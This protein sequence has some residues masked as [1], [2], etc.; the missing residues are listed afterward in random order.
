[1][2]YFLMRFPPVKRLRFNEALEG[3]FIE[4]YNKESLVQLR[5]A[6]VVGMVL[7]LVFGLNDLIVHPEYK[8]PLLL[9]RYALVSPFLI[10]V[11]LYL[12]FG[13]SY[14]LRHIF[15]VMGII[16][17]GI[18]ISLSIFITNDPRQFYY[19]G[20]T[21]LTLFAY[22]VSG[23][24]LKFASIASL[25]II[26]IF[27]LLG[28]FFR[29]LPPSAIFNDLFGLFSVNIMGIFACYLMERAKRKEFLYKREIELDKMALEEA[30]AQLRY[31]SYH[32]TLTGIYNRRAFDEHLR[33]E[34]QRAIRFG[35]P[36]SLIMMDIDD[37]K[38]FNDS[39]GHIAGDRILKEIATVIKTMV[40]RPGDIG[41][42]Y[43][44][45][46]F[47]V[48][49]VGTAKEGAVYLAEEILKMIGELSISHP[50]SDR[51]MVTVSVGCTTVIP[52]PEEG[53]E[54][55]IKKAD[56]ALYRAKT[57]GKNRVCY[58]D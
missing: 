54:S 9:I 47:V 35:Y 44:G 34:W 42:R 49:L 20:L 14:L 55:F 19:S 56:E 43:G 8:G 15:F 46:E 18:G 3:Q 22:T 4:F 50:E 58:L 38:K 45:E 26:G 21:L 27:V 5:T 10:S 33:K 36:L 57:E 16:L 28:V 23:L 24:R 39:K 48:L 29:N 52:E 2:L 1:M 6:A 53:V 12:F 51:G 41:A 32:D 37:F 40:N 25:F 7:Y 17:T 13:R 31:L 30:N 11:I